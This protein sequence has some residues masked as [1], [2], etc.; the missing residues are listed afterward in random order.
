MVACKIVFWVNWVR[1]L[2]NLFPA[3]PLDG[4]RILRA[5]LTLYWGETS[6]QRATIV[7][8]FVAQIAAV[9]L[10]VAAWLSRN[11]HPQ[12]LMPTWFALVLLAIF[13]YFSA[14]HER[15]KAPATAESDDQPFGYDFSQGYTSLERGP[16]KDRDEVGPITRWLEERREARSKRQQEIEQEEDRVMDEL[17][18]RI[19]VLGMQSLSAEEKSLLERVSARY[20]QRHDHPS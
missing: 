3:F 12:S 14:Q 15:Q 7:V 13:L 6:R 5:A 9:L 20:R 2:V 16:E 1:G 10:L 18:A 8:S 11:W 4:G 17:L 19:S